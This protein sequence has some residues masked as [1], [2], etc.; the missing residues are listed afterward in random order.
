MSYDII[1]N[2]MLE[3][4]DY[5]YN[6]QVIFKGPKEKYSDYFVAMNKLSGSKL[7]GKPGWKVA[8]EYLPELATFFEVEHVANPWDNVGEGLKLEPY[9]YQKETIQFPVNRKPV[10]PSVFLSDACPHYLIKFVRARSS[11]S[12]R[13]TPAAFPASIERSSQAMF[14]PNV[15]MICIPSAS[16]RT[17]SGVFP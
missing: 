4:R 5:G 2:I 11:F 15:R 12:G 14:F 10:F 6:Y 17:S 1:Q 3:L 8:K 13:Q 7:V 9:C 16:W